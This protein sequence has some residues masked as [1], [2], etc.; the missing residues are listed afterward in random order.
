MTAALV[1]LSAYVPRK[2]MGTAASP[3]M[4]AVEN[5]ITVFTIAASPAAAAVWSVALYSL[6]RWR[7]RGPEQPD[8][9]G[10]AIRGNTP[11]VAIRG[12]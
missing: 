1:V 4:A 5:T 6:L 11:V 8:T 3:T 7:H 12:L 9:D 2:L 10:P